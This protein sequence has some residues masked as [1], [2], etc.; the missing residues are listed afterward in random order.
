MELSTTRGAT[1]W[2]A[3]QKSLSILWFLN[4]HYSIDKSSP[5]VPILSQPNPVH[6][7]PIFV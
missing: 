5:P 2:V 7:N 3:T 6:T 1:G 4:V